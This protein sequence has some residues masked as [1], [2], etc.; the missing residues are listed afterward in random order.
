MPVTSW[1]P[2]G[3][4]RVEALEATI[5][6][7]EHVVFRGLDQE[8]ALQIAQL[9]GLVVGKVIGLGPVV[10]S[11]ELPDVVVEG[12][13]LGRDP[14]DAVPRHSGPALVVDAAIAEHLE[15]LGRVPIGGA[16]VVERVGHR[17]AFERPLL[18]AVDAQWCRKARSLEYRRSDVDHVV[19][20][21]ADLATCV[22]AGGPVHDRAI[23]GTAPMGG[24]LLRPLVGRVHRVS[25]PD[26]V[27]VERIGRA[28]V[29]DPR[30]HVLGRLDPERAVQDDELVE[31]PVRVPS[32]EAP[33]SPIT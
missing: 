18:H 29:V 17:H 13:R 24:D 11:I 28:E 6:E 23:P 14:G 20:L 2:A 16:G 12:G 5:V 26:C 3:D 27:V 10:R 8:Q 21:R 19:E 4:V 22:E 1:G 7:R 32:A 31:A 25:P 15:V 30:D 33:L 9:V